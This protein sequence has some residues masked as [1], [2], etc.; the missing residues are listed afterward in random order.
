M[1][2][3]F[4]YRLFKFCTSMMMGWARRAVHRT[5][6]AE[7]NGDEPFVCVY[8]FLGP[9]FSTRFRRLPTYSENIQSHTED[10]KV[11]TLPPQT[12]PGTTCLHHVPFCRLPQFNENNVRF[13]QCKLTLL[14]FAESSHPPPPPS[15]TPC[16]QFKQSY[17]SKKNKNSFDYE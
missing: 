3:R 1:C 11:K 16:L 17:R 4:Q 14:C 6:G 10:S 7:I 13:H 2:V 15:P 8:V 5:P 12:H 9:G